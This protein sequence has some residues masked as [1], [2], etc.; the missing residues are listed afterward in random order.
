MLRRLTL[1]AALFALLAL[2]TTAQAATIWTPITSGTTSTISSVVYQSPTR[3]WYATS[4]GT[5]ASWNG[6]AFTAGTGIT[7]GENFVDLAFQPGG[8]VGYAVTSNGHVWRSTDGGVTWSLIASPM[9]RSD[10]SGTSISRIETE[11][12][13]VQWANTT[14]VFLLGNN[15]TILRSTNADAASPDVHRD[16]Q[17]G[18]R[19][20]NCA[21][22]NETF[23]E[24]FTDATFL[25]ANP[26]DAFFVAQDFGQALS[27]QQRAQRLGERHE[28]QRRH[29]QQLHRQPAH[30]PGRQQPQPPLGRRSRVGR[31]RLRNAVPPGLHRRGQQHE[32]RHV[33]QRHQRH[34]RPVRRQLAG[35]RGGDGRQRRRDLHLR[36]RHQ[37]LQP[38]GRR[39]AGHGELARG[40]GLRRRARRGRR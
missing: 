16:Q 25:P 27:E 13:A 15:S 33:P 31:R 18:D 39:R 10:C 32:R 21:V 11:L 4:G 22:Q 26:A 35:R 9:T 14:T 30:R 3:F 24:N 6:S 2:A 5:I 40:G 7:P 17:G 23:T 28:D 20:N 38:A 37:L 34:R 8:S 29:R 19:V 1:A 36:R 12:N